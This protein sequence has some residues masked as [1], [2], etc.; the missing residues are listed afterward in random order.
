MAGK[1]MVETKRKRRLN[2]TTKDAV[3]H[4]L[5]ATIR[6]LRHEPLGWLPVHF[7]SSSTRPFAL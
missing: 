6:L 2:S 3:D 1:E 7:V 5:P 4:V